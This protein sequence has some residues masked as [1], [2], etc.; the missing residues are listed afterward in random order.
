MGWRCG[1]GAAGTAVAILLGSMS[2]CVAV[3]DQFMA[4]SVTPSLLHRFGEELYDSSN[5]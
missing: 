3:L 1:V 2:G 4:S 5:R